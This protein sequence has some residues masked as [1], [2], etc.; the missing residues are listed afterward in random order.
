M[1]LLAFCGTPDMDSRF[2]TLAKPLALESCLSTKDGFPPRGFVIVHETLVGGWVGVW[3]WT[4]EEGT[5][6]ELAIEERLKSI[7][8]LPGLLF[9][10]APLL[11]DRR[12]ETR[13][14]ARTGTSPV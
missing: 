3:P 4:V 13:M 1:S 7:S 5:M 14:G 6:V 11:L 8:L 12:E 9:V 10:V 2:P